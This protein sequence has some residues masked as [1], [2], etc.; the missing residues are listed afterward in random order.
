MHAP[1]SGLPVDGE[2]FGD[3]AFQQAVST[4]DF[5]VG[6]YQIGRVTDKPALNCGYPIVD[7]GGTVVGVVC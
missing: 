1:C 7:A 5:A 2:L 4:K 6:E 3:R